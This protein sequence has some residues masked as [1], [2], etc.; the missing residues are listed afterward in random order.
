MDTENENQGESLEE[1]IFGAI[2]ESGG[3]TPS[4]VTPISEPA[5]EEP[6][7]DEGAQK[8]EGSEPENPLREAARTLAAGKK[9]KGKKQVIENEQL[10]IP[11]KPTQPLL[12]GST[13]PNEPEPEETYTPPQRWDIKDKEEFHKLPKIAQK[14]VVDYWGG[15]ERHTQHLWQDLNRQK[16]RYTEANDV[17]DQYLPRWNINNITPAQAIRELCAAQDLINSNPIHGIALLMQKTGVT[18]EHLEEFRQGRGGAPAPQYSP[19]PQQNGSPNESRLTREDIRREIEESLKSQQSQSAM[20][21]DVDALEGL[22]NEVASGQYQYPEL[23]DG[24]NQAGNYW[25][26]SYIE[27][28]KPLV[29]GL[30]KTQPQI[31]IVEATKRAI[32]TLRHFDGQSSGSPSPT[33][34]RLS[35]QQEIQRAK[36]ASVSVKGRGAA[37]PVLAEAEAGEKIE[38]SVRA[39]MSGTRTY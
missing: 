4:P 20:R 38:D 14:Q 26:A 36:A 39:A 23:W 28:V 35:P 17:L 8:K 9:G 2:Q 33:A 24:S 32:A 21:G 11:A 25:N 13:P 30:R 22:R 37:Q 18:P 12:N 5:K 31:A 16:G 15:I 27:R 34:Q 6:V 1:A 10:D 19:Q 7:K 29:E 3:E